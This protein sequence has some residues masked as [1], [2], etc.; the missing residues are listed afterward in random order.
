M[1]E[2]AA[3]ISDSLKQKAAESGK[4][5]QNQINDLVEMAK[6][7]STSIRGLALI[8]GFAL[9]LSSIYEVFSNLFHFH[10]TAVLIGFYSLFMG[11]VAIAM[12]VDPEA[13]VSENKNRR[14][15]VK[16]HST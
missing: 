10:P 3:L 6:N 13:L 12:E 11:G 15:A 1:N 8:A 4:V 9:V 16:K 2:K 14:Q 7:G 5:V